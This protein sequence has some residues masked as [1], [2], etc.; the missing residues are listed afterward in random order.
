MKSRNK[1]TY[2]EF[3]ENMT[4]LIQDYYKNSTQNLMEKGIVSRMEL[5][6]SHFFSQNILK[7]LFLS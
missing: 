4:V 7:I 2:I 1:P 3:N 6:E 5:R